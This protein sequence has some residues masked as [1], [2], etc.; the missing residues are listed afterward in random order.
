MAYVKLNNKDKA[1]D[2]TFDTPWKT[3]QQFYEKAG[4]KPCV[5]IFLRYH[6]CPVCQMEMA[7]IK[8]DVNLFTQKKARVF[9]ILQ[10]RPEI[11][12]KLA[13]EK[14][15][16]YTIICDP[17]GEIF[18]QY[19]VA[20]GG[21]LKYLHPAGLVAAIKATFKGFRHGRFEGH[22]TQTPAVFVVAPGKKSKPGKKIAYA[23]Y[24]KTI[25]DVPSTEAI[26]ENI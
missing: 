13:K 11:V 24:G 14:D 18:L 23:Y 16:P 22:E 1:P 10:S 4:R 21:I 25:S 9:V 15:W 5:L 7:R 2:F 8:Q 19:G 20:H 12:A 26:L 17:D 3:G 6:G